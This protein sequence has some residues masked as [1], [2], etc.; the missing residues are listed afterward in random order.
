MVEQDDHQAKRYRNLADTAYESVADAN[1]GQIPSIDEV[2]D[3]ITLP[4]DDADERERRF[5]LTLARG[6]D[7]RKLAQ[8]RSAQLNLFSGDPEALDGF[9][10][11]GDGRRVRVRNAMGVDWIANL[12]LQHQNVED[13]MNTY[14][15]SMR[16]HALIA[17]YLAQGLT[18]EDAVRAY[19]RDHHTKAS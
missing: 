17:P 16:Q 10:A 1:N 12:D 6:A 18:T 13:V 5:R 19:V 7:K 14:H 9:M 4:L 3:A 11:L 15:A 8:G 2:A